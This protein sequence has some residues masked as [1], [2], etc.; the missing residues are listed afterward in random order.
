MYTVL[1]ALCVFFVCTDYKVIDR[2]IIN[3][4]Q[5]LR[6]HPQYR[7]AYIYAYIEANMSYIDAG[8]ISDLL[9]SQKGLGEIE[10][11]SF[12]KDK[13]YGVWTTPERK[14][15]MAVH[16]QQLLATRSVRLAQDII[17]QNPEETLSMFF[18]QLNN[19]RKEIKNPADYIHGKFT[20]SYGG[21]SSGKKDDL[22]MAWQIALYW[23]YV[24]MTSSQTYN[25]TAIARG[26]R[27]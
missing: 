15:E 13:R 16:A 24:M 6:K 14:H 22:A 25:Q 26:W 27:E 23:S 8:R 12:D 19:Y 20:F 1:T 2:M 4:F 18:D 11:V 9:H 7:D 10:V 21:K 5:E 3:H 17:G